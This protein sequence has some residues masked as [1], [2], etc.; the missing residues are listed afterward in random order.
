MRSFPELPD[1]SEWD[2]EDPVAIVAMMGVLSRHGIQVRV[3]WDPW[4]CRVTLRSLQSW[5]EFSGVGSAMSV[6]F[7]RAF[8]KLDNA[9][10]KFDK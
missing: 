10:R 1:W 7:W 6:A 8:S 2:L 3:I 4:F 9:V 5:H